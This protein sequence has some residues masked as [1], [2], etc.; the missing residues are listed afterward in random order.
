[1]PVISYYSFL[2]QIFWTAA[3]AH[4]KLGFQVAGIMGTV[5]LILILAACLSVYR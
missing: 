3:R 4:R 1:M 5:L 2:I